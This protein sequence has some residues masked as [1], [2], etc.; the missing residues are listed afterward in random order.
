MSTASNY[1]GNL[2]IPGLEP[3][4]AARPAKR[5]A[6]G[7]PAGSVRAILTLLVVGMIC[8]LLLVSPADKPIHIPAYLLYLL[9]LGLGHFFAA[10]GSSI[11]KGE[12]PLYLPSGLIRLLIIGMLVATVAYKLSGGYDLLQ[13]QLEG[14]V[15]SITEQPFLPVIIVGGFFLGVVVHILV[16][17][18][19]TP[20][21]FEDVEAWVALVAV[22]GLAVDAMITLVINPSLQESDP[23]DAYGLE[24]FVAAAVA[25]YFGARS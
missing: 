15:Q 22:F 7:M 25:F 16:G 3:G 14:S 9:F 17:R 11:P 19:N 20:Y 10:H 23:L 13:K 8:I 5:H 1:P 24:G 6:L 12:T 4:G 2:P 21:W 18:Q